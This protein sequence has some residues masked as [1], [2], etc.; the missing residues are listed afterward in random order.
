M[1]SRAANLDLLDITLRIALGES[2]NVK[3][4]VPTDMIG[5]RFFLQPPPVSAVVANIEGLDALSEFP[6]VDSI[7][8]HQRPG[9]E[10]DWKDGSRNHILS[11]VGSVSNYEDL[12][13]VS[14]IINEVVKVSYINIRRD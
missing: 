14:R 4:P 6:G 12:Q 13:A 7:S 3:G 9:A 1:L 11:V 8:V 5:Y 10:L 2:I